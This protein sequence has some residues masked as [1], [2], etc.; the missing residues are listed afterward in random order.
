MQIWIGAIITFVLA[1]VAWPLLT[2][3]AGANWSKGYFR[4]TIVLAFLIGL[5][6]SCIAIFLP[7]WEGRHE[8]ID[9]FNWC[10]NRDVKPYG[11]KR[12]PRL[13]TLSCPIINISSGAILINEL[14][15]RR[16][17]LQLRCAP[18]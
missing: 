2:L 11:E 9:F 17:L 4:F 12:K 5:T 18:L 6:S 10:L 1:D 13:L 14:G 3:P 15:E 8:A 16:S 7:L